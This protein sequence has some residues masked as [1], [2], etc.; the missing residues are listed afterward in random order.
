[1]ASTLSKLKPKKKAAKKYQV[2][3]TRSTLAQMKAKAQRRAQVEHAVWLRYEALRQE[4]DGREEE[5]FHEWYP[6]TR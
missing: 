6:W 4:L 3:L 2:P 5:H 1:M